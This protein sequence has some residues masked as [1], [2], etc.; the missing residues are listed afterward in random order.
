MQRTSLIS[1][2]SPQL[3]AV[4]HQQDLPALRYRLPG[5]AR[6]GFYHAPAR[7]EQEP[8]FQFKRPGSYLCLCRGVFAHSILNAKCYFQLRFMVLS[9]PWGSCFLQQP[10]GGSWTTTDRTEQPLFGTAEAGR[11]VRD[12]VMLSL[13]LFPLPRDHRCRAFPRLPW[14]MRWPTEKQMRTSRKSDR[15]RAMFVHFLC[16][17]WSAPFCFLFNSMKKKSCMVSSSS[18]LTDLCHLWVDLVMPQV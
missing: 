18:L 12:C 3:P 10:P 9:W 2:F 16:Q 17:R 5:R 1:P 13:F 11:G 14:R 8:L 15:R 7:S 6:N 4:A